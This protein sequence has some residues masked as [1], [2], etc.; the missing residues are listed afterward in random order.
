MNLTKDIISKIGFKSEHPERSLN[1]FELNEFGKY[2]ISL[3]FQYKPMSNSIEINCDC[4]K[5]NSNGI[6]VKRA[7]LSNIKTVEELQKLFDLCEIEFKI[8]SKYFS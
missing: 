1:N 8:D 3:M 4:N 6:V 5:I 2:H 7:Y